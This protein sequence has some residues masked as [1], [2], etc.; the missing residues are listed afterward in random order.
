MRAAIRAGAGYFAGVFALGFALGTARI[1]VLAPRLGELVA[2]VL[3]LPL[4]LGFS[5]WWCGW[6]VRRLAVPRRVGAG[7]AMGG[8]GFLLLIAAELALGAATGGS[9]AAQVAK[10][11]TAAGALGLG[12]QMLFG[13]MP[14]LRISMGA[15]SR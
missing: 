6:L 7:A 14:L 3:E 4:M 15:K 8:L 11:G 13:L 5:W 10:W 2:V 9:P 1:L 12:G